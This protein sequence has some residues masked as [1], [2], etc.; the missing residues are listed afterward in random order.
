MR[1]VI[2]ARVIVPIVNEEA[3]IVR[4][5]FFQTSGESV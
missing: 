1:L 3:L 2:D 4:G 5:E